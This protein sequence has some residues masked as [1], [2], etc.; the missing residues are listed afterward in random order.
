ML[1]ESNRSLCTCENTLSALRDKTKKWLNVFL[2]T[3]D[4]WLC[5]AGGL[6]GRGRGK[7]CRTLWL[8]PGLQ[9]QRPTVQEPESGER[10]PQEGTVT[11]G[12]SSQLPEC[13]VTQATSPPFSGPKLDCKLKTLYQMYLDPTWYSVL[14][15]AVPFLVLPSKVRNNMHLGIEKPFPNIH[16]NHERWSWLER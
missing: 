14:G 16:I 3:V 1:A 15:Q 4:R 11:S 5:V 8:L 12:S 7:L 10:Y 6:R 2:F 13:C 9:P